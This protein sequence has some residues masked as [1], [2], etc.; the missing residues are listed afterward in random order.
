[1]AKPGN[2]RW[3]RAVYRHR[4]SQRSEL[5]VQLGSTSDGGFDVRTGRNADTNTYSNC[6]TNAYGNGDC[7]TDADSDLNANN[8][9]YT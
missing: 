1:L 9:T 4:R 7:Y 2:R 5:C 3:L 8:N 6:I